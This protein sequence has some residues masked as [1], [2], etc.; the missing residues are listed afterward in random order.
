MNTIK[1]KDSPCYQKMFQYSSDWY[2]S[3][4]C[5]FIPQS[6]RSPVQFPVRAHAWVVP[7]LV[8]GWSMWERQVVNVSLPLFLPL[9]SS[10]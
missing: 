8:P 4:G 5:A 3:V 10:L 6:Q 9:F 2:G 7:S 1:N